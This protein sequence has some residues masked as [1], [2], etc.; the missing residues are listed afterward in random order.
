ML[1][2]VGKLMSYNTINDYLESFKF[3]TKTQDIIAYVTNRHYKS[4][5]V[6]L[7][8]SEIF[9]TTGSKEIDSSSNSF[10]YKHKETLI[11]QEQQVVNNKLHHI[12][13]REC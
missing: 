12:F 6:S 11:E 1:D 4:L 2:F 7:K 5:A 13:L 10:F 8:F 9:N 3:T